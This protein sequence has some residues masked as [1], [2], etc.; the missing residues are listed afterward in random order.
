MFACKRL[1]DDVPAA[2]QLHG[3]DVLARQ[4]APHADAERDRQDHRQ[5]DVVVARHLEDHRDGGHRRA[6]AA[7]DHRAHADH[8]KG[9]DVDGER[10][11]QRGKEP[12]RRRRR[13]SRP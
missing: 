4:Q 2:E 12:R 9:R 11:M 5:D 7:A 8:G 6:G 13:S 3:V 1:R 10:E